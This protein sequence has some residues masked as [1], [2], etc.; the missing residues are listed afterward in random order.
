VPVQQADKQA[1]RCSIVWLLV[2]SLPTLLLLQKFEPMLRHWSDRPAELSAQLPL[3]A[4]VLYVLVLPML[5]LCFWLW[6][7]ANRVIAGK[8]FPPAG[9]KVNRDTRI[10]GG[11]A[12]LKRGRIIKILATILFVLFAVLPAAIVFVLSSLL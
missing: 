10:L 1:R 6:H 2:L 7:F 8:R 9:G 11:E 12:A 5:L 4:L 3:I